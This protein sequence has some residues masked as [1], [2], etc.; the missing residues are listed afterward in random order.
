MPIC[1]SDPTATNNAIYD[2]YLADLKGI[3]DSGHFIGGPVVQKFEEK[4]S[5]FNGN[6]YCVG[7]GSGSDPILSA[8]RVLGVGPGDEVIC[9]AFGPISPAEAAARLGATPVFVDVRSDN[10]TLDVDKALSFMSS[11]TKAIVGVHLFGHAAE[12]DRIVQHARTYS[13]HVIEDCRHATGARFGSRRLGTYGDVSAFSF[14]PENPLG[15]AGDAGALNTNNEDIA[16]LVRRLRD[17]AQNDSGIYEMIGYGS[18]M[19]A[20][21]AALLL[22]KLQELD[23]NNAETIE[24]AGL[25]NRLFSGTA[26]QTPAFVAD[27]SNI[28]NSY[29]IQ[30]PNRD[31]VIAALQAKEI[32]FAVPYA[33]P[34]HLQPCFAYL[35]IRPGSFPVAEDLAKRALALPI[36]GGLKKRQLEEVANTVI[37]A[38]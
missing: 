25:Y 38:L 13:I 23:E 12:I 2:D 29:V 37:A 19:D 31:R 4:F 35:Q 28:Y 22:Q 24:N 14:L 34:I 27:G 3:F 26:V 33:S 5:R 36:C 18:H 20:I 30:V 16:N 1:F 9:P 32:G 11:R 21:Q 6:K 15:A 8:L 17:H 10:Y 7:L